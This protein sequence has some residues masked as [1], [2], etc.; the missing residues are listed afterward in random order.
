MAGTTATI[1]IDDKEARELLGRLARFGSDRL[2]EFYRDV[3]PDMVRRTRERAEREEAPDGSA[4]APLSPAYAAYKARKRPGVPIL[5]FDFHMLGDMFSYQAR[6]D[7]L[8]WGT[9]AVWGATHQFG[10][11]ERGIPK[12]EFLGLSDD[13]AKV[14]IEILSEHLEDAAAGR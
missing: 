11:R 6:P 13:D 14:L 9:N 5:K 2:L 10:D 7:E 1:E 12:R 4:W 3:G 8:L